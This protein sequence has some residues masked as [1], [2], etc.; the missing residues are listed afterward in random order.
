MDESI[1]KYY[2]M[3]SKTL[4]MFIASKSL[5]VI[6]LLI[7]LI[8]AP[9]FINYI[10]VGYENVFANGVAIYAG[11]VVIFAAVTFFIGWLRYIRYAI[12]I[13]EK[14]VKIR[15]GL[16][17]VEEIGVPYRRIKDVRVERSL[18]DQM[19]GLSNL[20]VTV[21]GLEENVSSEKESVI[22]L[23]S[24]PVNIAQEIQES[25]L[26]KSE[27]EEINMVNAPVDNHKN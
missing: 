20:V 25:I 2:P 11:F 12:S 8:L 5:V 23:P 14:D 1:K 15:R 27:V 7:I 13:E 24:L 10:P 21:L 3:G 4:F 19:F 22:I 26:K 18:T 17:S 16:F 9:F 6:V